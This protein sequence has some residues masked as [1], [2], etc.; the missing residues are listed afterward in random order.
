MMP[1]PCVNPHRVD[2]PMAALT[3]R[4][5]GFAWVAA[6]ALA[7]LLAGC[8]SPPN[9]PSNPAQLQGEAHSQAAAKALRRGDLASA[10]AS[11]QAALTAAESVEDLESTAIALLNLGAVQGQ[12]GQTEAALARMDRILRQP[13]PFSDAAQARAAA[14][15]ALLLVDQ[16]QLPQALQWADRSQALCADACGLAPAMNNLRAHVALAGS[17]LERA[18]ALAS[19]AAE[20]AASAGLLAEQANGQRLAGRALSL[21]G[22]HERAAASLAQALLLD[23]TLGLPDRIA[24]DLQYAAENEVR[25]G[26]PAVARTYLERALVVS[27]AAGQTSRVALLRQQLQSLPVLAAGSTSR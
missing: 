14:R 10:T 6:S 11:Y 21:Q 5:P 12:A 9:K 18:A 2:P 3:N 8:T 20:Q 7:L 13:S 19:R 23:Q 24:L 26:Q 27:Q 22:Q 15:K 4:L 16:G 25:R 17:D 1:R